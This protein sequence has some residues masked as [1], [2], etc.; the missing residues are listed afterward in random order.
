MKKNFRNQLFAVAIGLACLSLSG[1][2]DTKKEEAKT[3][4]EEPSAARQAA[5]EVTGNRALKQGQGGI[6]AVQQSN[7]QHNQ[8]LNQ[9][10]EQSQQEPK[11]EDGQ[12]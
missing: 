3:Q 7:A 11:K 12:Q 5:D 8:Q 4:Q 1:C 10:L 9:A 2:S 6:S